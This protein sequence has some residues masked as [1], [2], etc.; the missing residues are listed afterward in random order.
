M[1][2]AF[3]QQIYYGIVVG[4]GHSKANF[5]EKQIPNKTKSNDAS[6]WLVAH[7]PLNNN[8]FVIYI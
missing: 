3:I 1:L 8:L 6:A 5:A 4:D 7:Y 2:F